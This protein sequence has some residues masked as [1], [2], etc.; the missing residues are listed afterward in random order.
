[1]EEQRVTCRLTHSTLLFNWL[2]TAGQ[3]FYWP[4]SRNVSVLPDDG[5][6]GAETFRSVAVWM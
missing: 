6:L 2:F 1:M 3:A 5:P 4:C